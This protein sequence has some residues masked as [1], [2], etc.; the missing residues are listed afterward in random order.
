MNEREGTIIRSKAGK[1]KNGKKRKLKDGK[2]G[3][4]NLKMN[5]RAERGMERKK[6]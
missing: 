1:L 5:K 2:R 6:N 3:T 4:E